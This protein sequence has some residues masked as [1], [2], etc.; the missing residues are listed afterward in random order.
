LFGAS[1]CFLCPNWTMTASLVGGPY[2]TI[3]GRSPVFSNSDRFGPF[4]HK[5]G[6]LTASDTRLK[7]DRYTVVFELGDRVGRDK[8]NKI[9]REGIICFVILRLGFSPSLML[10]SYS[11]SL[12]RALRWRRLTPVWGQTRSLATPRGLST[13]LSDSMRSF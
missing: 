3:I 12:W 4:L 1:G 8:L 6:R 9:N 5:L 7:R 2:E 10:R 13:P 11:R